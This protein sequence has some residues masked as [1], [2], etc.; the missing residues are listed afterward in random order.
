MILGKLLQVFILHQIFVWGFGGDSLTFHH[1]L[2]WPTGVVLPRQISKSLPLIP[3]PTPIPS[4]YGIFTYIYHKNQPNV[5]KY[6]I[7]GWYGTDNRAPSCEKLSMAIR[8][9]QWGNSWPLCFFRFRP[10]KTGSGLWDR[11]QMASK[12]PSKW[13]LED[14]PS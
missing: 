5:G 2:E 9:S 13:Y 4:M 7:H 14:H 8:G 12:W 11:L 1:H 3:S 6:T 10:R